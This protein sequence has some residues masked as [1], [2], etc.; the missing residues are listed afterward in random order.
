MVT[1]DAEI[2]GRVSDLNVNL[3][4]FPF[5]NHHTHTQKEEEIV[6]PPLF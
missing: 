5:S 1:Q 4:G 6:R 3:W 2:F